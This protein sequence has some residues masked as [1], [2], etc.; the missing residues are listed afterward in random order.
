MH[1][2]RKDE[3]ELSVGDIIN[4]RAFDFKV[5]DVQVR[6]VEIR[7]I[8]GTMDIEVD[9]MYVDIET[10]SLESDEFTLK[11]AT[12]KQLIENAAVANRTQT[13]NM[14]TQ[15]VRLSMQALET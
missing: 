10:P 2:T 15:I 7:V 6:N 14:I 4:R 3:L 8:P 11:L 13:H 1:P 12:C 9:L 5:C